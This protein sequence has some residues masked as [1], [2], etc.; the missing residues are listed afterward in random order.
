[1]KK[2]NF[3]RIFVRPVTDIDRRW[4]KQHQRYYNWVN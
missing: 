2:S 4:N 3:K 1:M